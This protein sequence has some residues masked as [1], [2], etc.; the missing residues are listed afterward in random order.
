MVCFCPSNGVTQGNILVDEDMRVHIGD[1]GLADIIDLTSSA[2]MTPEAAPGAT[3]YSSP[4]LGIKGARP[5]YASD[6][7]AFGCLCLLVSR[8]ERS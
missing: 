4:E 6:V 5:N 1:Y 2:G 8:C 7:W 3:W